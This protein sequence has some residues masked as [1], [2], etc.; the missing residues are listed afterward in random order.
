MKFYCCDMKS[1]L[2]MCILFPL[3]SHS[4]DSIVWKLEWKLVIENAIWEV[5]SFGNLIINEGDKLQKYDSI[6]RQTFS[7]SNKNWGKFTSIDASNPMKILLFSENQQLI[8]YVDNTLSGQQDLIDLNQLDFSYVT[9]V[10]TSGQPDKLWVFDS[11]NSKIA[12]I[13]RNVI[14]QQRIENIR[15]LLGCKDV[16][17]LVEKD[18]NLYLIDA[19][20]GILKFD[21]YGTFIAKWKVKGLDFVHFENEYAYYVVGDALKVMSLE[22][23]KTH[24]YILPVNEVVKIKKG[25]NSMYLETEN[26]IL[27]YSIQILK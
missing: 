2:L 24:S 6:G 4:Q 1:L 13:S 8:S 15:G 21:I 16:K 3:F 14:Q 27:K 23:D 22:T 12:L 7:Q 26:E 19:Q 18:N 11:D 25:A 20:Q 10:A 9:L 17:Q 5:D